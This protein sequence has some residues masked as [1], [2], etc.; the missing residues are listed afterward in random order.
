MEYLTEL[1]PMSAE[2]IEIMN[3]FWE[4]QK[5]QPKPSP[6]KPWV[7][8][9]IKRSFTITK[10]RDLGHQYFDMLWRDLKLIE[11]NELYKH[12]ALWL[13][14]EEPK[15]HFTYLNPSQC[16]EAIE[17]AIQ[18]LNDDRRLEM[19]LTGNEPRGY[20]ELIIID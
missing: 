13:N 17:F 19:D 15:A 4:W 20:Y 9:K 1:P 3:G 2:E 16:I 18:H 11:R 5:N 10:L 6:Y 12:L 14:V 8:V 7:T